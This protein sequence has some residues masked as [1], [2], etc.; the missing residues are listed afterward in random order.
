MK[1]Y[2]FTFLFCTFLQLG[3][4]QAQDTIVSK[5][6]QSV[7][8]IVYNTSGIEVLPEFPGGMNAFY[9]FVGKTFRTPNVANLKGKIYI[10]FIVNN[11]GRLVDFKILKDLGYGTGD[12]AIRVLRKS[13]LWKPGEQNGKKVR[14]S[15][16]LPIS[17]QT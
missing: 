13:P 15:Y 6:T 12:E 10:Q 14:C 5:K 16:S 4:A 8:D 3:Y 11:D 7:D 1:T 9:A 2:L 17:I